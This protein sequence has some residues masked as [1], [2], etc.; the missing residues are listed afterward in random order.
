MS[1][2]PITGSEAY[3]RFRSSIPQ[4]K[5]SY[6]RLHY[7]LSVCTNHSMVVD[8]SGQIQPGMDSVWCRPQTCPQSPGV[9]T[10]CVWHS[11]C[12]LQTA[13]WPLDCRLQSNIGIK[14]KWFCAKKRCYCA[15]SLLKIE[16]PVVWNV[17]EFCEGFFKLIDHLELDRVRT[18]CLNAV[19]FMFS[20]CGK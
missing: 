18:V 16:Y 6:C 7:A 20:Q 9:F 15:I 13:P 5:V 10:P 12:L 2:D 4:R 19:C 8:Y 1:E 3:K 14:Q 17:D 11:W